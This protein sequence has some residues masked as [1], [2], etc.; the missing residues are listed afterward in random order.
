MCVS[1]LLTLLI[2][3]LGTLPST[4]EPVAAP[5]PPPGWIA[6]TT[7]A[8]ATVIFL[9]PKWK[10]KDSSSDQALIDNKAA[11]FPVQVGVPRILLTLYG[12]PNVAGQ[13]T[14]LEISSTPLH[15]KQSD[16][17]AENLNA[18]AELLQQAPPKPKI[19]N[20]AIVELPIG[21]CFEFEVEMTTTEAGKT[22]TSHK[23]SYMVPTPAATFQI[24]YSE[25]KSQKRWK[26]SNTSQS[27]HSEPRSDFL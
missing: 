25:L 22:L 23:F 4:Q 27:A 5:K 12:P 14:E 15:L 26:H 7:K 19:I 11:A 17:T 3:G 8:P 13:W 1:P 9:P 2:L 21:K 16:I 10:T 18:I 24:V 20:K 6:F